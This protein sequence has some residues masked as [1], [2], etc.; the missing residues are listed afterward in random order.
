MPALWRAMG[1]AGSP[2][3]NGRR[4]VDHSN[5]DRLLAKDRHCRRR[6]A[7]HTHDLVTTHGEKVAERFTEHEMAG[8]NKRIGPHETVF[9]TVGIGFS[10]PNDIG[11]LAKADPRDESQC[12]NVSHLV[13]I[14]TVDWRQFIRKLSR[15]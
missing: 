5:V 8:E 1:D 6:I 4:K 10:E 11:R 2:L 3:N 7:D 15:L 14:A 13:E 9:R 12:L